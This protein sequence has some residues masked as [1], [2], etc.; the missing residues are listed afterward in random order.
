MVR[1]SL[2]ALPLV[3]GESDELSERSDARPLLR[4]DVASKATLHAFLSRVTR[5]SA[6][7]ATVEVV[8]FEPDVD[9][10]LDL[11][12]VVAPIPNVIPV[13]LPVT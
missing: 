6:H 4:A 10:L 11:L 12:E 3:R 8:G 7:G 2:R 5:G 9:D 1:V 13:T